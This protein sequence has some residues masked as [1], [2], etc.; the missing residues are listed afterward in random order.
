MYKLIQHPTYVIG[1]FSNEVEFNG[2]TEMGYIIKS[3]V[4]RAL[5]EDKETSLMCYSDKATRDI[6]EFC[7]ESMEREIDKLLQ[8]KVDNVITI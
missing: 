6:V 8:Y 7:Y 2:G 4:I 5:R 1:A 3:D